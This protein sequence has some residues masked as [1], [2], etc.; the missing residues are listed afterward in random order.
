MTTETMREA[1]ARALYERNPIHEQPVDP[2]LRPTGPAGP[3]PWEAIQ[4]CYD[5]H[6]EVFLQDAD[7]AIRVVLEMLREP[8]WQAMLDAAAREVG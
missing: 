7:V 4:D 8:V 1:V 3:V 5:E 6:Y 2:D